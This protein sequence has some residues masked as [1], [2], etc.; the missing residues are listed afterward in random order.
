[1][2]KCKVE[3]E[4]NRIPRKHTIYAEGRTLDNYKRSIIRR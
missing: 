1:M 4:R 3:V 2:R